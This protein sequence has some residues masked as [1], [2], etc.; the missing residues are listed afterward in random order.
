[1]GENSQTNINKGKKKRTATLDEID[2]AIRT[3]EMYNQQESTMIFMPNPRLNH[4]NVGTGS[5]PPASTPPNALSK[6]AKGG[7]QLGSSQG[8]LTRTNVVKPFVAPRK[9]K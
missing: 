8:A 6:K 1:M 2:A 7:S 3:Q 5:T 9:K 4:C